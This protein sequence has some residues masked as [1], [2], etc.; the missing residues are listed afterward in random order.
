[1]L[2]LTPRSSLYH[3]YNLRYERSCKKVFDLDFQ[4][5]TIK[6]EFFHYH[7]WF[8]DPENIPMKNISSKFGREG[9]NPGGWYPPH[10]DVFGWRNTLG[11]CRLIIGRFECVLDI[12]T[13]IRLICFEHLMQKL[14]MI[15]WKD[16]WWMDYSE[17]LHIDLF[18]FIAVHIWHGEICSILL[19]WRHVKQI[20]KLM[21]G[22]STVSGEEVP[23]LQY[24]GNKFWTNYNNCYKYFIFQ[25]IYIMI[26]W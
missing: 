14:M 20:S 22:H 19:F 9:K 5:H 6:I 8:L 7:R 1:M 26:N 25:M 10:L 15:D 16:S 3:V 2:E 13:R 23:A 18:L 4:G 24:F 12:V 17:G 21:T 11:I